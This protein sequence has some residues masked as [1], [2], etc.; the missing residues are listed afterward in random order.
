MR[1]GRANVYLAAL[2]CALTPSVPTSGVK[3]CSAAYLNR[4]PT[5]NCLVTWYLTRIGTL[6]MLDTDRSWPA[7][8]CRGRAHTSHTDTRRHHHHRHQAI[9]SAVLTA[10]NRNLPPVS[11]F[12]WTNPATK[13]AS[14]Y[15][16]EPV[17]NIWFT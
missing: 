3:P 9:S 1:T 14:G 17:T 11:H 15:G 4:Q 13:P 6:L 7:G 10:H 5:G 16:P 2:R 12:V 8:E